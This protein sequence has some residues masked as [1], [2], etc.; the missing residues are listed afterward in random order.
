MN[1][2]VSSPVDVDKR[3]QM[4]VEAVTDYAIYMIDAGG[5]VSS[6]NPG[7]E[8]IKGYRSEDVLGRHFSMFFTAEEREAGRPA[9]ALATAARAGR[10]EQEGWRLRKDGTRFWALAVL[11]AI[12]DETGALVGF[13]KIT[14]DMTERR[15]A[16]EALKESERRF[17]L[18]VQSVI[19]YAIFMLDPQGRV[20]NWNA[21]A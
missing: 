16:E 17:R 3:F 1:K 5:R 10:F 9:L 8:R 21:G 12:Y 15:A 11:D 6:W 19:D 7:A 20:T 4:L 18:L 13:A 2:Q 14:R